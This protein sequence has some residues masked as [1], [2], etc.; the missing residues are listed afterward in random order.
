MK[1]KFIQKCHIAFRLFS[2]VLVRALRTPRTLGKT[3]VH[4]RNPLACRRFPLAAAARF[5]TL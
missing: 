2:A 1:I 4:G 5:C 3:T